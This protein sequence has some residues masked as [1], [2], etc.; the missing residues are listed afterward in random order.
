MELVLMKEYLD[1]RVLSLV[2]RIVSC[3]DERKGI[4]LEVSILK[5][6]KGGILENIC[7]NVER[8]LKDLVVLTVQNND[9]GETTETQKKDRKKCRYFNR[10]YCKYRENCKYDHPAVICHDYLQD[11]SC[12]KNACNE[13]HPKSCKNWRRSPEGCHR[14]ETC[15]YLHIDSEKFDSIE[16][17][18]VSVT[19]DQCTSTCEDNVELHA[20]RQTTHTGNEGMER[21]QRNETEK[22]EEI[23]KI[24][25]DYE[26]RYCKN[27]TDNSEVVLNQ[28][29]IDRIGERYENLK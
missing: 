4:L 29:E 24:V 15:Q 14:A 1:S 26:N 23:N 6:I 17:E 8:V 21:K 28:E 9:K 22:Q 13:R 12:R 10:G 18:E 25:V 3:E 16:V 7:E 19:C 27:D 20:H 2:E 5:R 11:G